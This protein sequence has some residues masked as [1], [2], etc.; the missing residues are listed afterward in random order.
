[1]AFDI[2]D[3][4][5]A[6]LD[7][8]IGAEFGAVSADRTTM[9]V[10]VTPKLLQPQGIVHGGVYCTMVETLGSVGGAIWFWDR[11]HVVGVSNQTDFLRA[12]RAG[13]LHGEATPIHRGRTQQLWQVLI[14]DDDGRMLARGQVR[15]ANISSTDALATT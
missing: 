15:L 7:Q 3:V 11:G 13:T 4:K 14:S 6:G 9:T 2:N 10:P 12:A 5:P 1:M 8:L